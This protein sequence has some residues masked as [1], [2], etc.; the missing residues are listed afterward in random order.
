M[1]RWKSARQ[2]FSFGLC[3]LSSSSPQPKSSVSTP[4]NSRKVA[5]TGIEPPSR[6]KTGARAEGPLD[7]PTG[8]G[9]PGAV[10]RH[11]DGRRAVHVDQFHFDARRAERAQVP[12]QCGGDLVGILPRHQAK[13]ELGPGPGGQDRLGPFALIAAPQ[14][15]DVER[16]PGPAALERR[17]SRLRPPERVDAD[18]PLKFL[19]VER[20]GGKLL[21]LVGA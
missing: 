6:M 4:S 12:L 9:H 17:E 7:R 13:A 18:L 21:P 5:T 20:Q 11:H 2:N 19:L 15:V 16:R 14:A 8:G 1:P 3:V 10:Q